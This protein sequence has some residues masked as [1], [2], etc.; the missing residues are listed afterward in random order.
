MIFEAIRQFFGE[1]NFALTAT[2]DQEICILRNQA[3]GRGIFCVLMDMTRYE[4]WN[5][6]QIQQINAQ[7]EQTSAGGAFSG[8]NDVLFIVVT[9]YA[10]RHKHLAQIP[11]V[12]LWL[13][14]EKNCR[15]I[16]YEDQVPDFYGLRYGIEEAIAQAGGAYYYEDPDEEDRKG[17]KGAAKRFNKKWKRSFKGSG[18]PYV[19]A[20][21]IAANVV[22]YLIIAAGGS[23]SDLS[24]M[25]SM[26]ANM[27]YLVFEDLQVWRLVSCMFVH[28]GLQHL[29]GNMFYLA[30]LGNN[31]ENVVGH[32]KYFLLYMLGGIGASLVS[33]AWYY[34][35]GTYTVSGGASGAIYALIGV[36]I[37]LLFRNFI[38][39]KNRRPVNPSALFLRVGICLMFIFYS[40]FTS[41]STDGAAHIGGFIF[42]ILL[43]FLLIG[44]KDRERR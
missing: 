12:S 23:V 44:G 35:N 34:W 26:G 3:G 33:A 2:N 39:W 25:L 22:Y 27:G 17:I 43:S 5:A 28:F 37:Y 16:V 21:L 13:A 9:N 42:G 31:I 32:L 11:G 19:T 20:A 1:Q 4:K 14:D 41:S 10:D 30:I 36:F 6:G 15:L 8:G 18:F 29:V 38:H 24:Y 40:S 7:L